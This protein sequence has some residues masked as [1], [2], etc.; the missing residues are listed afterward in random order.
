MIYLENHAVHTDIILLN[1]I[2][3][4]LKSKRKTFI[5]QELSLN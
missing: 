4:I 1:K 3:L 5:R 2:L